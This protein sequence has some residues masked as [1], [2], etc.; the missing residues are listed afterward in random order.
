MAMANRV[1]ILDT[2][3]LCCLLEV[4]GKDTCGP[5]GDKWDSTR[6][7][8]TLAREQGSGSVFVLPLATLIETGNHISQAK[9][10]R[11]ECAD[12]LAEILKLAAQAQTPWAAFVD[13]SPLWEEENLLKLARDWPSLAAS[14]LSIGDAT[15]KDVAEYY[16]LIGAEV[17]ILT[18]DE[19][20]KAFE[21]VAAPPI[22][23]RRR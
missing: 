18:G 19:G 4:P 10:N 2:S 22:P 21:P 3:V 23:R 20:L 11:Y 9:R 15:I 14:R 8:Q 17:E 12:R 16:A 6:I 13:Q 1:V 7:K 5:V